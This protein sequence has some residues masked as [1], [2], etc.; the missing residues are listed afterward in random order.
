MTRVR[1]RLPSGA[2]I[3]AWIGV[4][5][6]ILGIIAFFIGDFNSLLGNKGG[7]GL[8]EAHIVATL[9]ALQ[10]EKEEAQFQLTQIALNNQQAANDATQQAINAQIAAFQ[11]TVNA[12]Q[13]EK[14]AF[15][16]TQNAIL[17]VTAT[18]G[19]ANDQATAAA[20]AANGTATQNALDA[21]ATAAAIANVTPTPT[22]EPTLTPV[23]EVVADFRAL[24]NAVIQPVGDGT[25]QFIVQMVQPLPDNPPDGLVYIW[26][27]DTD[28]DPNT[29]LFVQ[30][31]G[32]DL[33]AEIRRQEGGWVG[34]ARPVAADGTIGDPIGYFV[35]VTA[36]G[37][38][39]IG[40]IDG[41][42]LNLP[43]VFDWVARCE[44]ND[45][46]YSYFPE[47]G[48]LTFGQ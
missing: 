14:D 46:P 18:A 37:A 32:V 21:G 6:A 29:G 10:Q 9:S 25:I 24:T 31:I 28:R 42:T 43:G 39:L 22:P 41:S 40:T 17:A 19:A 38:S 15:V 13:A 34:T 26:S 11:A 27:M 47:G 16:A 33:R 45:T 3:V 30:D 48:H 2:T 12:A 1:P 23:P 7:E 44:L 36:N 5:S 4:I 8:S 20:D 35:D